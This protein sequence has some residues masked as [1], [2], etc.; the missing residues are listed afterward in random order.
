MIEV[1]PK[2]MAGCVSAM[3]AV[4][5]AEFDGKM[6]LVDTAAYMVGVG[7]ILL[8][9]GTGV[10]K[11]VGE[12]ELA[13]GIKEHFSVGGELVGALVDDLDEPDQT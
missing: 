6:P 12:D 8:D 5:M 7:I 13:K 2:V 9:T 1:D 11:S 3:K 4:L 10:L